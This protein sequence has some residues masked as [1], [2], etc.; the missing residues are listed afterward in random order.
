MTALDLIAGYDAYTDAEEFSAS[1]RADAPASIVDPAHT[2]PST[3]SPT[4]THE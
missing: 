2:C 3:S 1:M 4:T